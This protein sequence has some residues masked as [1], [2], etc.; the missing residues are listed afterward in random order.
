[1]QEEWTEENLSK[2]DVK[3]LF[4]VEV[5]FEDFENHFEVDEEP[6]LES[7]VEPKKFECKSCKKQFTKVN[8]LKSHIRFHTGEKPFLCKECLK[9][10]SQRSNLASH[11]RSHAGI[12]PFQC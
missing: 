9:S 5:N 2:N 8:Y 3:D 7:I 4:K 6:P 12:K 1:M 10:F 11:E